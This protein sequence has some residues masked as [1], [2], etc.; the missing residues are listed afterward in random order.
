MPALAARG[1]ALA[2]LHLD[3]ARAGAPSPALVGT[4]H[5]CIQELGAE[6]ALDAALAWGPEVAFSHNMRLLELDAALAAAIPTVKFMHGYF[7][8]CIGGQKAHL[9]PHATPCHKPLGPG[10][11]VLYG[12]R[13]CGLLRP[14]YLA[15]QW[16]WANAQNALFPAYAAMV[17]ASGHMRAEYLRNGAT[18]SRVHALPLFPTLAGAPVPAPA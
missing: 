18:P 3:A 14:G 17:T 12:P 2:L 8:T 10:C 1:H 4:P 13:R 15:E 9:F 16:R 6:A 5:F 7:G 11:L